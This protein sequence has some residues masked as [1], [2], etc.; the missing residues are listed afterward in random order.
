MPHHPRFANLTATFDARIDQT[1]IPAPVATVKRMP[2]MTDAQREEAAHVAHLAFL[3][4]Q[5]VTYNLATIEGCEAFIAAD[6]KLGTVI[7]RSV[8]PV[9]GEVKIVE[10]S[11]IDREARRLAIPA[12]V[13]LAHDAGVKIQGGTPAIMLD[14]A[15]RKARFVLASAKDATIGAARPKGPPAGNVL[16]PAGAH[17]PGAKER[18][19]LEAQV[20]ILKAATVG[21]EVG[22]ELADLDGAIADIEARLA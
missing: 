20:R 13:K 1:A 8:A 19:D 4:S 11:V 3:V 21:L 7:V 9:D 15:L 16:R 5:P 18:G 2:L 12:F 10:K 22:S 17:V 14:A 6:R